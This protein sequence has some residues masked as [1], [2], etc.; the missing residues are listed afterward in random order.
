[1]DI[2]IPNGEIK[3]KRNP[4]WIDKGVISAIRKRNTLF[5]T[6]KRTGKSS[7]FAKY[8]A[9]RNQVVQILRASK[10]AFF[11]QHLNNADAKTFWKMVRFLNGNYSSILT[12]LDS[13]GSATVKSSSAKAD[14]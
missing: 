14:C 6:A 11:N 2:C 13:E 10:H 7:D 12:L 5:R 8:K 1:M 4:P 3:T 9:K